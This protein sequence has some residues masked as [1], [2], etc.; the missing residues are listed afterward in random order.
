MVA[1][2]DMQAALQVAEAAGYQQAV[3]RAHSLAGNFLQALRCLLTATSPPGQL[4]SSPA[5]PLFSACLECIARQEIMCCDGLEL[6][7]CCA[8]SAFVAQHTGHQ[9]IMSRASIQKVWEMIWIF[10]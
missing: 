10:C 7:L 8:A 9:D 3:A 5:L 6:R 4:C 2:E 1:G